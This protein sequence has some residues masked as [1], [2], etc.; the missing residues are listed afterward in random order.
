MRWGDKK[1][2]KEK[3]RINWNIKAKEGGGS[4]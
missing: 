1:V 2:K 3:G 4:L